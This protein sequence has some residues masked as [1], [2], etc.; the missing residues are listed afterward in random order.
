MHAYYMP[1]MAETLG[2]MVK[3]ISRLMR[4]RFDAR[5]REIGV[6]RAQWH[7]MFVVLRN[8][9]INQGGLAEQMEIEPITACRMIDRL[10]DAG[11]LERRHDPDDRRVRR[12][13]LTEA[14]RPLIDQLEIIGAEV[15]ENALAGLSPDER[16]K[17]S[18]ILGKIRSNLAPND[19]EERAHG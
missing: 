6:T 7:T 13:Y 17:L 11:L 10:E 4:R 18:E 8:E 12:I 2:F 16:E 19:S 1:R 9:G 3:D 14:A 5:A 15:T